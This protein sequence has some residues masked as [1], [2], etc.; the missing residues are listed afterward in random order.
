MGLALNGI[1]LID[2]VFDGC[3]YGCTSGL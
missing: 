2:G 3:L 1:V